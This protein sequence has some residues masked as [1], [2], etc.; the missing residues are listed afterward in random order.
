MVEIRDAQLPDIPALIACMKAMHAE[1]KVFSK[2]EFLDDHADHILRTILTDKPATFFLKIAV[3]GDK[4][5]GFIGAEV[6]DD[7][8]TR[9]T[10]TSDHG[11]YVL[12][13]YRGRL[14]LKLWSEYLDWAKANADRVAVQVNAGIDDERGGKFMEAS[15]LE[16]RGLLYGM[17]F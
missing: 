1:S 6:V 8:W 10:F 7:L 13:D 17:E 5:V 9:S 12:P 4:V 16:P 2:Y 11:L 3:D 15:G 14:G